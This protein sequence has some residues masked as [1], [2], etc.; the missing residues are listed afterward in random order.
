MTERRSPRPFP[1][2]TLEESAA[3][4]MAIQDK[5]AGR[6]MNRVLLAEAV[7]RKPGS[8]DY[9]DLLSA[10]S[11]YGLTIGTEKAK[12]VSLT[13][14]GIRLTRPTSPEDR[15]AALR[16][17][18]LAPEG[19]GKI[20]RHYDNAKLPAGTFFHNTLER[21]FGV[22]REHAV[23]CEKLLQANGQ[24][25]GLLRDVSGSTFVLGLGEIP[26]AAPAE[27]GQ[28]EPPRVPEVA[29]T[30]PPLERPADRGERPAAV[31]TVFLAHGKNKRL[32]DQVKQLVEFGRFEPV[33]ADERESTAIPVPEKVIDSMHGCQAAIIIVSADEKFT[34]ADG[35]ETYKVNENVL[36]EIGA[37]TVLY[38]KKVIL[39][40]DKRIPVPSN[41]QGLY[42]C[43]LDG[44][45]LSWETGLKLQKALTEF[46]GS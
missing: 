4:A 40:W 38:R 7:G 3:V 29:A 2:F 37:A 20:Y 21:Q 26:I 15:Q 30:G 23:E 39:L 36:I 34:D 43:E 24:F 32:L 11:K 31:A 27:S 33:V 28:P 16:E 8:S 41:L 5:N 42:R 44:D 13:P 6:P 9:R 14:R 45:T 35:K 19:L 10:S 25:A 12:D 46:R 22:P 1:W 17:A 18:A